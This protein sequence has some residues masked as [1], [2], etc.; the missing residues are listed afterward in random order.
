MSKTSKKLTIIIICLLSLTFGLMYNRT[1]ITSIVNDSG[2]HSSYGGGHSH[3]SSSHSRS[4]SSSRSRSTSR[5]SS[6]SSSSSYS[7]G[8]HYSKGESILIIGIF[9]LISLFSLIIPFALAFLLTSS[10]RKR[11]RSI[12]GPLTLDKSKSINKEQFESIISN[13]TL[14]QFLFERVSDV[15]QIE[16]SWMNFD[17]DKLRG[18]LTDELYNQYEMQLKTLASKGQKNVMKNFNPIDNMV[19]NVTNDNGRYTVTMELIIS[20]IDYIEENNKALRGSSTTP[21]TMHYEL[22]FV[23]SSN[24]IIDTCPSCGN[25]LNDTTTQVCPY[26]R[27]QITQDSTKWVLSK[28]VAKGQR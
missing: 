1:T 15:V 23:S 7:S 19:T 11:V 13:S 28:K 21:I 20:F 24:G 12:G 2:F 18:K 3:S 9:I 27:N 16:Y 14:E 17:Y 4:S 5:S 6:S 26:C 22:V 10:A 25:K 8:K